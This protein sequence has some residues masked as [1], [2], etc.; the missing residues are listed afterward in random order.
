MTIVRKEFHANG[1]VCESCSDVIKKA[2]M[3][4][5]G[6]RDASF[7]YV[8]EKGYVEYDDSKTSIGMIFDKISEKGYECSLLKEEN[9]PVDINE[10]EKEKD[11]QSKY[12]RQNRMVG[13]GMAAI[14]IAVLV[15]F[16]LPYMGGLEVP[17]LSSGMG[18][19]LLFVAGLLTGFHCISMC[20]S[21]VV[22]YTAKDAQNGVRSKKSHL[23]YCAG[24]TISYT[25]IGAI[26]GFAGSI[27]AFTPTM[28][29]AAAIIAGIF[30]LL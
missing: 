30:L 25:V 8:D 18:Y 3:K 26:F 17:E 20:G 28:R 29:G 7:N 15:Y 14:G 21:F 11:I 6:V 1:T 23:L 9:S 19:G 10:S 24:K 16:L 5:D 22:S 4:A 12:S 13:M 27:I 2:A